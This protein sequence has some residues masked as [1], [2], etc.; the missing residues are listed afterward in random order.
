MASRTAAV[1][2]WLTLALLCVPALEGADLPARWQVR[3]DGWS[4]T[5]EL[6]VEPSGR[7]VGTLQDQAVTGFLA[8]RRLVLHRTVGDRTEVWDGWLPEDSVSSGF[9]LAGSVTVGD[10]SGGRV[11]PWFAVPE[12]G[13]LAAASP[14]AP[15]ARTPGAA[16]PADS[17]PARASGGGVPAAPTATAG[18]GWDLSGTWVCSEGQAQIIQQGRG[19]EVILPGGSQH[20]GRF[21][22]MDTVVV[23][24][25]RGCCKGKIQGPHLIQ[26]SD[27]AIWQRAN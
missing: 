4:G 7:A 3:T 16:A 5:L 24:L 2:S 19:L 27:G 18:S 14:A 17:P 26:W 20:S 21:T 13:G 22:A 9:F 8:G 12:A 10:R 6:T 15:A 11:H 25:R 23:G 1:A